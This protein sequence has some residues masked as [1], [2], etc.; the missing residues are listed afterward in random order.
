M[1]CVRIIRPERMVLWQYQLIPLASVSRGDSL[2]GFSSYFWF[3]S[4]FFSFFFL[5]FFSW[6]FFFIFFF[7]QLF[8]SSSFLIY[9]YFFFFFSIVSFLIS[10]P[11]IYSIFLYGRDEGGF[12]LCLLV[13]DMHSSFTISP[14]SF[15]FCF[16]IPRSSLGIAHCSTYFYLYFFFLPCCLGKVFC[17]GFK[18]WKEHNKLSSTLIMAPAL[19]NSPQ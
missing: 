9:M 19:S 4:N 17:A 6:F 16:N 1:I 14:I 12:V 8:C 18:I 10:S 13:I 7:V 15:R 2:K 3:F 11:P 5:I